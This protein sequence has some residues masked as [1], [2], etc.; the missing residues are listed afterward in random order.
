MKKLLLAAAAS[1][2]L[3]SSA[4]ALTASDSSANYTTTFIG[5]NNGTGFNAW[6][7]SG[8]GG[9]GNYIGGSGLSASSWAIFSGGASGNSYQATRPFS[10][11]MAVGD[12]FTA[13]LGYTSVQTGGDGQIGINLF[14]GGAFRLGFKFFGG[15]SN[16]QLNDGG[17]DF[18]T[19]LTFAEGSPG[20]NFAFTRNAGNG[21]GLNIS[22]GAQTY[23]DSNMTSSLGTMAIDSVQFYS[24]AQGSGNNVGFD[25]LSVVPEPSTYALLALGA[26]AIGGCVLRRRRRLS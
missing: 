1:V 25:N 23:I 18:G 9:G 2:V 12:T 21:Y 22:Q 19:G 13:Q 16:W 26:V 6:T 5:L 11:A 17:D 4:F 20:I 10:T 14:S 8:T 3:S 7:G 24:T 15:G